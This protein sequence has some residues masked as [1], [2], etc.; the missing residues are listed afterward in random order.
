M[1]QSL[2]S[3]PLQDL[4]N[5]PANQFLVGVIKGAAIFRGRVYDRHIILTYAH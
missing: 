1:V 2:V 3:A 4:R 5:I